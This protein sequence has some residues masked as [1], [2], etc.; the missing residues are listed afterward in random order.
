MPG[1]EA[2]SDRVSF[3]T[4]L[5][6]LSPIFLVLRTSTTRPAGSRRALRAM[7][8]S[9]QRLGMKEI[10][11]TCEACKK[12]YRT[13]LLTELRLLCP[14]CRKRALRLKGTPPP[15]PE[16]RTIPILP[17]SW[18]DRDDF[19]RWPGSFSRPHHSART[20]IAEN[21]STPREPPERSTVLGIAEAEESSTAQPGDG[22]LKPGG[23]APSS[24]EKRVRTTEG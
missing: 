20:G 6:D 16:Q 4:G 3:S 18:A 9:R 13:Q 1:T 11:R 21:P 23:S 24:P 17:P 12:R 22:S 14:S 15:Q 19:V 2:A 10:R 8:R 7:H 5:H